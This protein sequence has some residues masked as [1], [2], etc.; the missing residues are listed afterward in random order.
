MKYSRKIMAAGLAIIFCIAIV[1][2]TGVILSVRN[3][4]VTY[5]DY[6]GK[7]TETAFAATKDNLNKLK[8][9]GLLFI[10]DDDVYD[11]ISSSE[12]LAVESYTK[13]FPC[14]VDV[15]IRERVEYFTLKTENGYTVYDDYGK[16]IRSADTDTAPLNTLDGCPNVVLECTPDQTEE[17]AALCRCFEE[18]FGAFRRLVGGVSAKKYLDL[19]IATITLR[20][21][22]TISISE[23]KTA[24][25]QK[26][27]KA[28]ETYS[29][30]GDNERAGG[31]ITVIDGRDGLCAVSKY[32]PA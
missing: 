3:V 29:A 32:N 2:G 18:N 19:Q 11:K 6:S 22:V 17:L 9:S 12:V 27:K 16:A 20:S 14:T 30:L 8:G 13:K 26:V 5:I 15:V 10:G 4:N 31:T 7:Y 21:G 24:T 1:I 25:E 23:W 28:Y